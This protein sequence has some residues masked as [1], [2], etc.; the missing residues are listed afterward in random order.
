[1]ERFNQKQKAPS[2]EQA[3]WGLG[4]LVDAIPNTIYET[5]NYARTP[6]K[7]ARGYKS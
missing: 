3:Q 6:Q 1:M 2:P 5:T 4:R 7:R